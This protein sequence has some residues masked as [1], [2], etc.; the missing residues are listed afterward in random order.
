[1]VDPNNAATG[2]MLND[3]NPAYS[4]MHRFTKDLLDLLDVDEE[5]K[6]I[7][8]EEESRRLD[9]DENK[10]FTPQD[11]YNLLANPSTDMHF[12]DPLIRTI[13]RELKQLP[14]YNNIFIDEPKTVE[15]F[16]TLG[17]TVET[18]AHWCGV[19][20]RDRS[21]SIQG[22]EDEI[23]EVGEILKL[24]E[25]QIKFTKAKAAVDESQKTQL[26]HL[27]A[28][29]R[30]KEYLYRLDILND[31]IQSTRNLNDFLEAFVNM[32][33]EI[34]LTGKISGETKI[35][36][37]KTTIGSYSDMFNNLIKFFDRIEQARPDLQKIETAVFFIDRSFSFMGKNPP[38]LSLK[39]D[40]KRIALDFK[41]NT[42]S[43]TS[44]K[45]K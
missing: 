26:R 22:L 12:H 33:N 10:F 45:A 13:L 34:N 40:G 8:T 24:L 5:N 38:T 41:Y 28:V 3:T 31:K 44:P 36:L 37:L 14:F 1:M 43:E 27:E 19:L 15:E 25:I 2:F 35:T 16:V 23:K 17:K 30:E 7:L 21:K 39:L 32:V 29:D 18:T 20:D 9:F 11:V 6:G 4:S 42:M